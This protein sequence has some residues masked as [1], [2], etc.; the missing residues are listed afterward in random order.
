M[1][2][3]TRKGLPLVISLG[4]MLTAGRAGASQD[5][6]Y[7][8][9]AGDTPCE[10]AQTFGMSCAAL[11]EANGLGADSLIFPGQVLTVTAS[12][13]MPEQPEQDVVPESATAAQE[14]DSV[15]PVN[16]A[17]TTNP[18]AKDPKSDLLSIYQLAKAQDPIFAAQ[19]Y[20]YQ[21]ALEVIPQSKSALR[22][23]LSASGS[24]AEGTSDT[25]GATRASIA[26]SQSLY[27]K[28]SR[29]AVSQ[30]G[31]QVDQAE[32]EFAIASADLV[33]RVVNVYFFVLAARDNVELSRRNE[34]AISRQLELAQ[35]RLEVGLGTRTDLF[36]ARA[37][38]EQAVADTIEAEKLLDDSRQTL[39]ALVGQDVGQLKTLPDSVTLGPPLPDDSEAWVAE[40]L[41]NNL[42]LKVKALGI[43]LSD[44]EID[45]Q[46]AQRLPTLGLALS[47]NYSDTYAGDDSNARVLFS[48]DIPFY[49]GGLV[50]SRVRQAAENLKAA[51]YDHEAA[52][53][54]IRR[55]TRQ[56]F[57]G[58]KSRLRG[59]DALNEAV[60]AGDN[61]LVAK[62]ESFAA[63]LT[64]N[65][66]VLDAQRDL[67]QAERDYLA[68]RYDYIR[69]MLEL[70]DL[71]G[72]LDEEDIQRVNALLTNSH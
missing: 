65:I 56:T 9:Q 60:R 32:L 24:H 69:Q 14:N 37:R 57:L 63:G 6:V 2:V 50:D 20:R 26:L 31:K 54:E 68:A 29:I 71:A 18:D 17:E 49:Q 59:I 48:V 12:G 52:T 66:A 61:A 41:E 43:S 51:R 62:E 72:N 23:Q 3:I 1:N 58:I 28:G 40:A 64:T 34:R 10:I 21:A 53:R 30:A 44:L 35:E 55:D 13:S 38:F 16:T 4:L 46:K 45:R 42:S 33:T 39:I 67:F 36:D 5:L 22:P 8:V 19:T 7:T 27:N 25:A 11:L 70:E 47:G 15:T